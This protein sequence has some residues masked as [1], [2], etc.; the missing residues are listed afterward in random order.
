MIS[1]DIKT[2]FQRAKEAENEK[3]TFFRNVQLAKIEAEILC[4]HIGECQKNVMRRINSISK[5]LW[6]L[7]SYENEVTLRNI[8]IERFDDK[9]QFFSLFRDS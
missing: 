5:K 7:F 6:L 3:I 9:T 2:C 8:D 1:S 4:L